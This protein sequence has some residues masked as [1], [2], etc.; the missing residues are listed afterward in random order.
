MAAVCSIVM[1]DWCVVGKGWAFMH[2]WT[3][4]ETSLWEANSSQFKDPLV[5]EAFCWKF[6]FFCAKSLTKSFTC[7]QAVWCNYPLPRKKRAVFIWYSTKGRC[8]YGTSL[9][10]FKLAQ[11]AL[12]FG[13]NSMQK[14][15]KR[16]HT[17]HKH[18]LVGW[19]TLFHM[20]HWLNMTFGL[21]VQIYM[22]ASKL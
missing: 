15:S 4:T 8:L 5:G 6:L 1:I 16:G 7:I 19:S 21:T 18:A 14:V 20:M 11:S 22:H 17:W 12:F 9:A 10:G 3:G 13:L 2:L